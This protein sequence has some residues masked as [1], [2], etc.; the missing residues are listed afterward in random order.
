[1]AEQP[2]TEIAVETLAEMR[3]EGA[4]HTLLDVRDP[5][6]LEICAFADSLNI[7]M[8][9]IPASLDRLPRTGALVVV[10]HLGQR[11]A[12]VAAWLRQNGFSNAVNLSGGIDA[13]AREIDNDMDTY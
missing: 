6:E 9:E 12:R 3:R 10:C 1:M 7:P 8:Q 13:W 11:S 4:D 5:D 2:V